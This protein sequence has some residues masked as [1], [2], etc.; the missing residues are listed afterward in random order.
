[1]QKIKIFLTIILLS[2][3]GSS[4]TSCLVTQNGRSKDNGRHLGWYKS[5]NQE[6]KKANNSK[7][8][9]HKTNR[10]AKPPRH[11]RYK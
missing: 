9:H 2:I 3:I 10:K 8:K 5:T 1:M 4:M 6:V 11:Y 7:K